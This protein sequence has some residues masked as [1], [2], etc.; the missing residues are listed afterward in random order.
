MSS[1]YSRSQPAGRPD[2][3]PSGTG[4]RLRALLTRPATIAHALAVLIVI[5][6]ALLRLDAYVGKYGALDHPAWARVATRT[7]APLTASIKPSNIAW[8]TEKAPYVGGDP[9]TYIKYGREM[10]SFYQGHVREPVFVAMT[11]AG[12]RALDDQDAG[13]SLAS[14]AGSTAAIAGTYLAGAALI[15]PAAGLIAAALVAIET[16]VVTWAV[17]GWRDDTF[18]AALLFALWGLLRLRADPRRGTAV[19]AGILCAIACLT[20]ITA[21]SFVVPGVLWILAER[22]QVGVRERARAVAPAAAPR[23]RAVGP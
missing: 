16:E 4:R 23:A 2:A 14:A 9:Y 3:G 5:Y 18:T 12:L 17:D 10:R 1:E 22:S 6:G 13:V 19:A 11:H 15:S 20:R 8:R 7:I 21:L